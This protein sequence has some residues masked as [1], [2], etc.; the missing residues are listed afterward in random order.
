MWS[1]GHHLEVYCEV[2]GALRGLTVPVGDTTPSVSVQPASFNI[3]PLC[4]LTLAG[5]LFPS[6]RV[7]T[8]LLSG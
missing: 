6:Y 5:T 1:C 4:L 8:P 7:R 2:E 3:Q